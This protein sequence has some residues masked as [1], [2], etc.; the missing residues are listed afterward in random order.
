VSNSSAT[1][2]ALPLAAP[3]LVGP[4][5]STQWLADHLG[6]DRLVILDATVLQAPRP[7]GSYSWLSGLDQHLISGHVPGAVFADILEV[8]SDPTGPFVFTRPSAT[9]FEAAAASV[10]VDNETTVVVYD[11]S[12]G[13][14]AA[15][16][17]WLFRAFGYEHVAVLDGGLAKWTAEDRPIEFG[18]VEPR[19]DAA[20]TATEHPE[21]W[22]DK[23][24]I[25]SMLDGTVEATLICALPPKEFAGEAG[26]R[27]RLGHIPGSV[28]VPASRLVSRETNALLPLDDLRASF[29]D[30]IEDPSRIVTYC[31]GGITAAADALVLAML[32]RTDVAIYDGSLNEWAADADAPLQQAASAA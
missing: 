1:S 31:G 2:S 20:F 22:V 7:D 13:Q 8:F 29:A 18:Y 28:N 24:D 15:R 17:W 27:P 30:V 3:A 11:S 32:G 12:V 10:G 16:I 21:F 14:W 25:Q 23:A 26:Q 9:Q 4:T 5:V 6:S 19:S